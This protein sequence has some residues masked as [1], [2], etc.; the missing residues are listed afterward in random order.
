MSREGPHLAAE[1]FAIENKEL[2]AVLESGIFAAS[3]NAVKV[4]RFA[5]LRLR[6]A[7]S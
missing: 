6:E 5:W 7:L 1:P 3:S 4:L 2:E